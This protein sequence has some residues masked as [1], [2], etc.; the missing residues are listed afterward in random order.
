MY[1]PYIYCL[2][3]LPGNIFI[4][5]FLYLLHYKPRKVRDR[6]PNLIFTT[7]KTVDH[8]RQVMVSDMTVLKPWIFY[9]ELILYLDVFTKQSF[10]EKLSERR[11]GREKYLDSLADV[12]ELLR[13]KKEPTIIHTD[14]GSV[15]S[16][17]AYIELIQNSNI[18]RSMARAG[19]PTDNPVNATLNDWIKKNSTLI[20]G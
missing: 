18:A 20:S 6:Y 2:A 15:Y 17:K 8:P 10:T 11:G 1:Y 14:Q 3:F 5:L 12:I 13:N 4:V 16:S 9:L 7:W 19:K